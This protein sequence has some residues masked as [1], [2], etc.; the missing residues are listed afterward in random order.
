MTAERRI[1]HAALAASGKAAGDENFPVA[2]LLIAA[3]LRPAIR[4]YYAF[5]RT[6]DDIADAPALP[7]EVKR[8]RLDALAAALGEGQKAAGVEPALRLRQVLL[9]RDLPLR[10]GLDLLDAFRQDVAVRHYPDWPALMAYCTLSAAPVG[11]FLLDLHGEDQALHPAADALCRA[12]QV[13]NHLQDCG[14]DYRRLNRVYLP[15]DWLRAE[16][17]AIEELATGRSSPGL[18]RVLD[19]CLDATTELLTV[20]APLAPSLTRT[21]LALETGAIQHLAEDLVRQLRRR[22]PLAERVARGRLALAGRALYGAARTALGRW[23]RR[24]RVEA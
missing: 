13:I 11:R 8:Q 22:D 23:R 5:A 7:A 20:S 9:A 2:S 14:D 6:A 10:H 24:R 4:A 21:G 17:V 18:R 3:D 19:R 16:G 12:L 15:T 1:D